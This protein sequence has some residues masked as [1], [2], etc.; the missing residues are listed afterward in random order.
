MEKNE[1]E[2]L[3]LYEN[4]LHNPTPVKKTTGLAGLWAALPTEESEQKWSYKSTPPEADKT[5]TPPLEQNQLQTFRTPTGLIS[6]GRS[7]EMLRFMY[8]NNYNLDEKIIAD[9]GCGDG[10]LSL[11]ASH[12]GATVHAIDPSSRQLAS[13]Q[14]CEL[15]KDL[16]SVI[17]K[18]LNKICGDL[19]API[20]GLIVTHRARAENLPLNKQSVDAAF[21]KFALNWTDDVRAIDEVKR[22][23]RPGGH[24]FIMTTTPLQETPSL[25]CQA[26]NSLVDDL[27]KN[28]VT[29]NHFS[30]PK[31]PN[32]IHHL[33]RLRNY[34][35]QNG[36]I[37]QKE[38]SYL[39]ETARN[40][41]IY[42]H[43][44]T[45]MI[46]GQLRYCLEGGHNLSDLERNKILAQ[47]MHEIA[48][49]SGWS[50]KIL[51]QITILHFQLKKTP[52]PNL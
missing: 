32:P 2:Y 40:P 4:P 41:E 46:G 11:L 28:K 16:P 19:V 9:I 49:E 10:S 34:L 42:L 31:N 43:F 1:I 44:L 15:I 18:H 21:L 50:P 14:A 30:S 48:R 20:P 37:F 45:G 3:D 13:L 51:E 52:S 25:F 8:E 23:L 35:E 38:K 39:E 6:P 17:Q 26:W 12:Q 22:V 7:L 27:S 47:K 24:M 33:P 29:F 36:F 5:H